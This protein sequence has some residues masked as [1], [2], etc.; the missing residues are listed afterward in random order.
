MQHQPVVHWY[1]IVEVK[2]EADADTTLRTQYLSSFKK[3]AYL[4]PGERK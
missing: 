1:N 3:Q 4:A 2:A